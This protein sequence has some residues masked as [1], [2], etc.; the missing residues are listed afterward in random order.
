MRRL[1]RYGADIEYGLIAAGGLNTPPIIMRCQHLSAENP[2]VGRKRHDKPSAPDRKVVLL[3]GGS[4]Q[5]GTAFCGRFATTYDIVA[6][7]H[8]RPLKVAS[9][10]PAVR[11]PLC[12]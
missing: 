11:R 6:V 12:A 3:T 7:R 9:P 1:H 4:G 5:I 2:C 8:R 10:A